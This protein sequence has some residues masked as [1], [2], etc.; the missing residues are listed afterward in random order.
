MASFYKQVYDILALVP[1]GKVISYGQI[2][3]I[4]GKPQSAR[5]VGWAMKRCPENLP[6]HRVV[7]ADGSVV[8]G[9]FA[10]MRRSMLEKEN[11]I[12]L[13]DGRVDMQKCRAEIA[14]P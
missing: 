13:K 10:Q 9:E 1:E 8:G 3:C 11:V 4:I 7:M 6:W 2:A 12:F 14:L 5:V